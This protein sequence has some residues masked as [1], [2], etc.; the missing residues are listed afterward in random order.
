MDLCRHGSGIDGDEIVED[1]FEKHP[2]P[3]A[4]GLRNEAVAE[5]NTVWGADIILNR[6]LTGLHEAE[7]EGQRR[8]KDTPQTGRNIRRER[9]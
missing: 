2:H 6:D 8:E 3:K 7:T 1:V 5:L 4:H 9:T